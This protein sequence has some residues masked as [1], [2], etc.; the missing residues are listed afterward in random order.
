MISKLK[1]TL[2]NIKAKIPLGGLSSKINKISDNRFC[3]VVGHG[4]A[5]FLHNGTFR[6]V[7][8]AI[9]TALTCSIWGYVTLHKFNRDGIANA[10]QSNQAVMVNVQTDEI[11]VGSVYKAQD[12]AE[13][14]PALDVQDPFVAASKG[15]GDNPLDYRI[16]IPDESKR[17]KI[18]II[19]TGLGLSKEMTIGALNLPTSLTLGFSPYAADVSDWVN[20]A[21]AKGFETF[22]QL[23]MQPTDYQVNDPGPYAMLHNLSYGENLSRLDDLISKSNKIVGFYSPTNDT[24]SSSRADI[25]PILNHL[26]QKDYMLLYGNNSNMPTMSGLCDASSLECIYSFGR[27]DDELSEDKIK[28]KLLLLEAEAAKNGSAVAYINPYPV[29]INAVKKWMDEI[30]PKQLSIVPASNLLPYRS[31]STKHKPDVSA[32]GFAKPQTEDL[33]SQMRQGETANQKAERAE[34]SAHGEEGEKKEEKKEERDE[35]H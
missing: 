12:V 15:G 13:A 3:K 11:F 32:I 22:M 16:N 26:R 25:T 29:S 30:N 28:K 31:S 4:S 35:H 19:V 14:E 6:I 23:P 27:L 24:F 20:Q 5:L 9:V 18:S 21:V 7:S 33:T 17:S 10:I 34:S 2:A 8:I 1:N